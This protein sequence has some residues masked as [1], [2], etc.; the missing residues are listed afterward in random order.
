MI[1][2]DI[3]GPL[4]TTARGNKYIIV[5][6]DYCSKRCEV[7]AIK[8]FTALTTVKFLIDNWI[9]RF[10]VPEKIL[11]DQGT[12][13]EANLFQQLCQAL[14]IEKLRSNAYH[15]ECNGEVEL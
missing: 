6:I 15:P 10:G 13:F 8:D 4:P 1:G 12:N 7:L 9:C 2:I 14:K 3:T 11:T 5:A